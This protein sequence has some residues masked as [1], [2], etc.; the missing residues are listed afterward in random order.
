MQGNEAN[1]RYGNNGGNAGQYHEGV[2][3]C[4]AP[5]GEKPCPT[6]VKTIVDLCR[7]LRADALVLE[8]ADHAIVVAVNDYDGSYAAVSCGPDAHLP[9]VARGLQV[10]LYSEPCRESP[11]TFL[12]AATV[13]SVLGRW[14]RQ[15]ASVFGR[16]YA[17]KLTGGA[18]G[19][20]APGEMSQD[21]LERIRLRLSSVIGGCLHL[22]KVDK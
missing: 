17:E 12:P 18:T 8:L 6:E 14:E 7:S 22:E 15:I 1:Q 11:G 2:N 9:S 4:Y 20:K 21:D 19:E 13:R 10:R 5:A 3:V 16:D